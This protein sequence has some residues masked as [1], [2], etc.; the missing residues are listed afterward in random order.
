VLR[1]KSLIASLLLLAVFLSLLPSWEKGMTLREKVSSI[2]LMPKTEAASSTGLENTAQ[3]LFAGVL[4]VL[5]VVNW[6]ALSGVQALL[7]PDV[8]LGTPDAAGIRPMENL[9][10]GIWTLSRNIVNAI[11]AFI[12]LAGGIYLIIGAGGEAMSKIKQIAPKFVL[13]VVLINFSWFFPRVILDAANIL[14]S[15]VYEIPNLAGPFTCIREDPDGVPGNAD[16]VPCEFV[17]QVVLFPEDTRPGKP[18]PTKLGPHSLR[19]IQIGGNFVDLYYAPLEDV[20][21]AGSYV[22]ENGVTIP[23]SSASVVLNGLSVNFAKLPN[24]GIIDFE[25]ALGTP[26][27][28]TTLEQAGAYLK[29]LVELV[30]HSV[31]SGA[32]GLALI[33]LMVV[34]IVRM[35]VLWLCIAFMPF[36][37]VGFAMGKPL[38]ELGKEGA[39][40]IWQTFLSYAF[41]PVLVA[42]PF[43]VGFLLVS[44]L[45]SIKSFSI[46]LHIDG[47]DFIKEVDDFHQLLWM[48]IAIGIVWFGVFS[49]LEKDKIAGGLVKGIKGVGTTFAKLGGYGAAYGLQLPLPGGKSISL[50][51]A[52]ERARNAPLDFR[53]KALEKEQGGAGSGV[54][55]A[56]LTQNDIQERVMRLAE[57]QMNILTNALR[58]TGR[59]GGD[60][61][62]AM[63]DLENALRGIRDKEG[64]RAF[65]EREIAGM[66][67][68]REGLQRLLNTR[69]D[70]G[71]GEKNEI[72]QK[73]DAVHSRPAPAAPGAR[74]I[75]FDLNISMGA[76]QA[77]ARVAERAAGTLE[78]GAMSPAEIRRAVEDALRTALPAQQA[79]IQQVL[80]ALNA[81]D[82][83]T[84]LQRLRGLA[85]PPPP[86][87]T[88]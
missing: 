34:L 35:A 58:D 8:I 47:I 24:F 3:K 62:I 60:A 68:N 57:D 12:L 82:D 25:D 16:D 70:L 49:I 13:A 10:H 44:R 33:A 2:E 14:T 42:V 59:R 87:P 36:I 30:L 32:V 52:M 43:A 38:G 4:E 18:R 64:N 46:P 84:L 65:S 81:G 85:T 45:Y 26:G 21:S 28:R 51:G 88:T 66:T 78:S 79:G 74:P 71:A 69:N 37:F 17:W 61:G 48:L 73:F 72:L 50:G 23:V 31:L 19:G 41:L 55:P 67:Q 40:N 1:T 6:I 5:T 63:R 83:A 75:N 76:D 56:M 20:S 29:F 7:D 11:F 80:D 53:R 54:P 77:R 15:V 27:T 39:P 9:L 86:P 22:D